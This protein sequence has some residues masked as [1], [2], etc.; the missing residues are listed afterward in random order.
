MCYIKVVARD[1]LL[2]QMQVKEVLAEIKKFVPEIDFD[3]LFIKTTGDLDLTSSLVGLDK[4]NFFTKEID[5]KILSG[6]SDLAIHSAKDLPDPLPQGLAIYALTKGVNSSD[7]LV[8]RTQ[9]TIKTLA[10]GARIGT[11]SLRRIKTLQGLRQDLVAV[12]IRGTIQ[13]RLELLSEGVIDG[14]IVAEAALIRLELTHLHRIQL[15]GEVA[16]MQ[17]RLAV[18]GRSNN[19]LLREMFQNIHYG[20]IC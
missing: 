14:L 7:A 5:E 3:M 15:D 11:S 20:S 4:T 16:A 13:R 17:G 19:P 6:E 12:D 8:L 9:E 2:S 1:S 10:Y 18:V